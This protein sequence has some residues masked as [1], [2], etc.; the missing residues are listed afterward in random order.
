MIQKHLILID[1]NSQRVALERI[2]SVL[3]N[4]GIE[5]IYSEYNPTTYQKRE[6]GDLSFDIETFVQAL[7]SLP[8]FKQLDSIVCDYNLIENVVNGFEIVKIIKEINDNYR[9]Q[10]ILYSADINV[11]I[12]NILNKNEDVIT[13]LKQL[14]N[15]NIDIIKKEGYDQ[16]VIPHIKKEKPFDFEDELIKWF[17]SR[18]E[19]EFNY[20]FPK[21]QGKKFEDIAKCL[22]SRTEDS[23][24]FK[25]DLVEQIIAYLSKINGLD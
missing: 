22:E 20:L 12:G 5:L 2:K 7:N 24:E 1:D 6:N 21:Y 10:I 9:K 8:Y 14:I 11:V 23:I 18:K 17:Y 15:C 3:K 25:K 13:N 16:Y 19:D 4:D